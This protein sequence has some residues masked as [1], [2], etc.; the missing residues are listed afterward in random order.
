VGAAVW[1]HLRVQP[2]AR[3]STPTLRLDGQRLPS[4]SRQCGTKK[5]EVARKRSPSGL[6]FVA[7]YRVTWVTVL[8]IP[9]TRVRFGRLLP[10]FLYLT[11]TRRAT[12]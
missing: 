12:D 3:F 11:G 7:R 9:G 5:P 2:P 6:A 4:G 8:S 1:Q 10:W